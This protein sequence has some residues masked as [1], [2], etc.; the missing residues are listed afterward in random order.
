MSLL[1]AFVI[2][3]HSGVLFF[4]YKLQGMLGPRGTAWINRFPFPKSIFL[5][6][7]T[8]NIYDM[9]N[10]YYKLNTKQAYK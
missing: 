5:A 9:Q 3:N 10:Q 6:G 4:Y 1:K 2:F 8:I 7:E